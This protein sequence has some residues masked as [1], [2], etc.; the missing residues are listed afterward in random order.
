MNILKI[1]QGQKKV[2][3]GWDLV[4][5]IHI[6]KHSKI[7]KIKGFAKPVLFLL[8]DFNRCE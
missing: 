5:D 8:Q 6:F 3:S 7:C 2:S 1:Y 4:I